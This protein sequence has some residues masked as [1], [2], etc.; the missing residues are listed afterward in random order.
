MINAIPRAVFTE[1]HGRVQ[2]MGAEAPAQAGVSIPAFPI[3]PRNSGKRS[4]APFAAAL[5]GRPIHNREA[6]YPFAGCT[7]SYAIRYG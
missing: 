3:Y 1:D 7:L 4:E 6:L 5:P 2:D